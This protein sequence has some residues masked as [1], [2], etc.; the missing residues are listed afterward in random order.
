MTPH[1]TIAA[2]W[3]RTKDGHYEYRLELPAGVTYEVNIPNR[4]EKDKVRVIRR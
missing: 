4:S 1:G 3:K 2:S